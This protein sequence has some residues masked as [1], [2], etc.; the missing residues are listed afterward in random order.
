MKFSALKKRLRRIACYGMQSVGTAQVIVTNT[1][2]LAVLSITDV[3]V[4]VI[5]GPGATV[6]EGAV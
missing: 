2:S 6:M 1:E 3:A 5:V 4:I